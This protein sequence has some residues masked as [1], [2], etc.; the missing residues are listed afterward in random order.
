MII[1][2][3]KEQA[4][5][6]NKAMLYTENFPSVHSLGQLFREIATTYDS[7]IDSPAGLH[8]KK[9]MKKVEKKKELEYLFFK[10]TEADPVWDCGKNI[11]MIKAKEEYQLTW[12]QMTDSYI[13]TRNG[14]G[15]YFNLSWWEEGIM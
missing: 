9:E 15:F 4:W 10:T 2:A 13:I 11:F 14:I 3:T 5:Q 8:Y 6:A 1:E 12:H 7:L